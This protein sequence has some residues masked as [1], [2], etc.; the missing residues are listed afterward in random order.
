[1]ATET[2]ATTR[3]RRPYVGF[4]RE[5]AAYIR[6]K[7]ELLKTSEGKYVV[8]VAEELV[9]PVDTYGDALRAGYRRFGKGPLFVKRVLAEEPVAEISRDITPCRP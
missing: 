4:D 7:P 6:K 1:M 2:S 3:T 8:L 9:G 5:E